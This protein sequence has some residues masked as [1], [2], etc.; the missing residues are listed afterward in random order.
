MISTRPRISFDEKGLCNACKWKKI[1]KKNQLEK[2]EI[3][4]INLVKQIKS[5]NVILILL[6]Q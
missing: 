1:Q 6:F 4:F 2:R 3:E 5:K